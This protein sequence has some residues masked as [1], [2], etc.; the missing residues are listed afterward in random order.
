MKL[1]FGRAKHGWLPA[2]LEA[3]DVLFQFDISYLPNDFLLELT[4]ALR[5]VLHQPGERVAILSQEPVETEWRFYRIQDAVVFSL[6][7]FADSSR[8]KGSGK[9]LLERTGYPLEIVLPLWR[10]LR[11]LAGRK[12]KEG[13]STHWTHHW[14]HPFPSES[15][16][17]LSEAVLIAKTETDAP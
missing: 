13:F 10:G 17:A 8:L 1:M 4:E 2:E 5:F 15:L 14:A 6:V 12:F 3:D 16:D 7:D 9:K 11:E